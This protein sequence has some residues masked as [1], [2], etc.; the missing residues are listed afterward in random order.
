METS[1][2]RHL[3]DSAKAYYRGA[4]ILMKQIS[5]E[6]STAHLLIQPAVTCA[7]LSLKL[8]LKCLLA[9]EGKDKDDTVYRLAELFRNL[10]DDTKKAVLEKFDEFSNTALSAE[11]LARHLENLDNSFVRWRYIHEEDSRSVNLDDLEQMIL[12]TKAAINAAR[13]DWE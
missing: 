6:T 12:A 3:Y 1:N 10:K 5:P 13:P 9:F 4:D 2:E 8:Y 7:S 11:E